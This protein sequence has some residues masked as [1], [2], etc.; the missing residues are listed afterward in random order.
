MK[1]VIWTKY[2]PPDGLQ[3]KEVGKPSPKDNE[4]L[5][6][7]YATTVTSGDAKLRGGKF[8]FMYWLPMRIMYGF[9]KPKKPILG[10]EFAGVVE[11]TG[12]NVKRFKKGDQVFGSTGF[13]GG[14]YAEYICLSE[15]GALTKKPAN[16]TF[17]EAGAVAFGAS[18][19]LTFLRDLGKVQSGHKVLIYGASGCVGTY[20][21]Q[22]AKYFGAEV[23]GVC[24]TSNLEL[25][26][27]L[28]ADEVIDYT[29]EDFTKNGRTYDVIFDTVG[30]SPFSGCIKSLNPKGIYLLGAVWK[31]SWYIRALWTSMTSGK[32]VIPGFSKETPEGLI[33]LKEIIEAGKLKPVIDRTYPME[34][35]AEAHG[36]V[37]KGHKKGNVVITMQIDNK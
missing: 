28:G 3:L 31:Q 30:K 22:L 25:V 36:Y 26:K 12:K 13:A 19:A 8:P 32:K 24:G 4:L 21:V 34:Q 16:I 1:A 10:V 18:T 20:A 37:E 29:K 23:T 14:C 9:R 6:K 17:E 15:D 11:S 33:F 27:S 5:I 2:G 35:I 7:I